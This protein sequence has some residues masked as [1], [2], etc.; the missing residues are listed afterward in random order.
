MFEKCHFKFFTNFPNFPLWWQ[1]SRKCFWL[2]ASF[3]PYL[4]IIKIKPYHYNFQHFW[5]EYRAIKIVQKFS[6]ALKLWVI[7][8]KM[9]VSHDCVVLQICYAYRWKGTALSF[10]LIYDS[11]MYLQYVQRY[12][13]LKTS[14]KNKIHDF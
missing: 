8:T 12:G 1:R 5:T 11:I 7:L 2:I 9:A 10:P 4:V 13:V 3:L 6:Q 14:V